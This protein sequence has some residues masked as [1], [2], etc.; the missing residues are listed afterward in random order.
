MYDAALDGEQ[1]IDL[2]ARALIAVD[3]QLAVQRE[4]HESAAIRQNRV[5]QAFAQELPA[6][7]HRDRP[8]IERVVRRVLQEHGSKRIFFRTARRDRIVE[9]DFLGLSLSGQHADH[10]RMPLFDRER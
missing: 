9:V 3:D 8:R 7:I 2:L 10:G 1:V 6:L 4:R 5:G